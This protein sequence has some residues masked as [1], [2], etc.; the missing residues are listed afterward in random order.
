MMM[1]PAC[2]RT[3]DGQGIPLQVATWE[4]TT[5]LECRD[6]Q[7]F[8]RQVAEGRSELSLSPDTYLRGVVIPGE[9]A[10]FQLRDPFGLVADDVLSL[11][12]E[13]ARLRLLDRIW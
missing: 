3:E 9:G 4:G 2:L 10:F 5:L 7:A 12:E 1:H 11:G 13:E 8:L 6:P